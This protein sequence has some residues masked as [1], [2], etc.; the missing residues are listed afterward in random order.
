ME[1]NLCNSLYMYK[2]T[3]KTVIKE[4]KQI[5]RHHNSFYTKGQER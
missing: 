1:N 4:V 3:L 5:K 2:S